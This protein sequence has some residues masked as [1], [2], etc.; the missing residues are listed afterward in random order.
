M[1]SI[2]H[3]LQST[4]IDTSYSSVVF[5]VFCFLFR[6][7][8]SCPVRCS[9]EPGD[10]A[11]FTQQDAAAIAPKLYATFPIEGSDPSCQGYSQHPTQAHGND[12]THVVMV[13]HSPAAT[14]CRET[15]CQRKSEP[16][17]R[18]NYGS[19]SWKQHQVRLLLTVNGEDA[20]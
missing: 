9:T 7:R 10:D 3:H 1:S 11:H 4:T 18:S 14:L 16:P 15:T 20:K 13:R 6:V 2:D 19:C 12:F 8:V 5:F 17:W